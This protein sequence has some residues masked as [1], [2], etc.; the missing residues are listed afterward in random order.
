[1]SE[2]N[3]VSG[4][5]KVILRPEPINMNATMTASVTVQTIAER[6]VLV[7]QTV[8]IPGNKTHEGILVESVGIVWKELLRFYTQDP[9]IFYKIDARKWE[10][11]VAAIYKANGFEEVTLTPRSA[12]LGRDVIAVKRGFGSVR[13]LVV[14][15]VD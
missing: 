14:S 1:M 13:F 3:N 6:M 5:A 4:P 9:D 12:D 10:E 8:I 15:Y 7:L 11:I 2:Q